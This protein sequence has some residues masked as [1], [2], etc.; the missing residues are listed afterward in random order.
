[1][2]TD[3]SIPEL[4]PTLPLPEELHDRSLSPE[5]SSGF[6]QLYVGGDSSGRATVQI[7]DA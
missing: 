4:P 1:M 3:M 6:R 5:Y 2:E 7:D